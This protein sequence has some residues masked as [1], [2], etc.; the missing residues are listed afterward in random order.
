[1]YMIRSGRIP[2]YSGNR[3]HGAQAACH[4][5][6][7]SDESPI[8]SDAVQAACSG[9]LEAG[10]MR[11]PHFTRRERGRMTMLDGA[12]QPQREGSPLAPG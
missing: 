10:G 2:P 12:V 4:A 11:H 3:A 5:H 9:V 7:P 1:M 8:R 6:P